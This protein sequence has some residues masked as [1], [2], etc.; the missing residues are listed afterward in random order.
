M[1][2]LDFN[3]IPVSLADLKEKQDSLFW[4]EMGADYY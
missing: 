3:L 4:R 1:Y 2:H